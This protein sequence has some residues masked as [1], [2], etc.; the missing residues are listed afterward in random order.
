MKDTNK[1][2]IP[3]N[4]RSPEERRKIARMGGIKSGE[5]R[6]KKRERIE[7]IKLHDIAMKEERERNINTLMEYAKL[8]DE[9]S[10]SANKEISS[11]IDLFNQ[12][13]KE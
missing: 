5:S 8:Y 9:I 1:N 11:L 7:Y 4:Q 13:S 2:L 6:R 10:K 3:L 12:D